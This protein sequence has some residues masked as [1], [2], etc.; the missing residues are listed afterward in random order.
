MEV[1]KTSDDELY[2]SVREPHDEPDTDGNKDVSAGSVPKN[3]NLM[4]E[5]HY[6]RQRQQRLQAVCQELRLD[7]I[8]VGLRYH[9]YYFG[10]YL[11]AW[12]HES[13][14]IQF[15]DGRSW[16]ITANQPATSS[17]ADEAIA[18]E[19]SRFAT[20]RQEQSLLVAQAMYEAISNRGAKRIGLDASAVTSQLS[21]MLPGRCTAIDERLWQMR[22]PKDPDELELMRKA[23]QCSE[24]MYRRARQIIEPGVPELTVF[25]QLHE[26]AVQ[27]AGEPLSALLGNDYGC[28]IGGPPRKGHAPQAGQLYALD[29]GPAYRGYFADNARTFS[30]DRRPTDVQMKAWH[31]IVA[32]FGIVEKMARPGVRCRD[33]F[34]AVDD[35]FH[36][37]FGIG[38]KHHLGHGVGLQPHEY[39][40][41]NPQWDDLLI[42]GEVFT[43]EPSIALDGMGGT[44]AIENDYLVNHDGVTNLLDSPMQLA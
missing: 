40:H 20:M 16:L 17:A 37:H 44:L 39:P 19:A 42:E 8:A 31:V 5:P 23:I 43:I 12:Q 13:G 9:V 10:A 4:L 18:F 28:G 7:A 29:L 26:A 41:L 36:A 21:M 11:P 38:Q 34:A 14:F 27:E 25:T 30:V 15:A 6:S 22:R 24:A 2:A 32:V 33:I 3:G 35:H 1:R